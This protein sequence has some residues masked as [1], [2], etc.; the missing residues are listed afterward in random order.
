MCG[1]AIVF[2]RNCDSILEHQDQYV[3]GS[4]YTTRR[5]DYSKLLET[6]RLVSD[7]TATNHDE[8][9]AYDDAPMDFVIPEGP[10]TGY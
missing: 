3:V 6:G 10:N 4:Y 7:T 1:Q 5:S 2:L 9:T 8:S